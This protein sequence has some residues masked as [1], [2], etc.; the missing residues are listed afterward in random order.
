MGI[1]F[2]QIA[3]QEMRSLTDFIDLHQ[4]RESEQAPAF[5]S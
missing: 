3:P 1:E 4:A 5:L 2:I